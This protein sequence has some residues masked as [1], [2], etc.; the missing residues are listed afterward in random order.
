MQALADE[1]KPNIGPEALV[2][3]LQGPDV[4]P[5]QRALETALAVQRHG[6]GTFALAQTEG[7]MVMRVHALARKQRISELEGVVQTWTS[8]HRARMMS[9]FVGLAPMVFHTACDLAL[10]PTK[11]GV[12]IFSYRPNVEDISAVV[13]TLYEK[14]TSLNWN[15]QLQ[16]SFR[17]RCAPILHDECKEIFFLVERWAE[18]FMSTFWYGTLQ[19]RGVG[20]MAAAEF[21]SSSNEGSVSARVH[22]TR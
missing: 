6:G 16:Q 21:V 13:G 7:R 20:I 2:P 22:F 4:T 14:A 12:N 18:T 17:F 1:L 15:A 10:V 11:V 9:E 5:T 19:R 3:S 8:T